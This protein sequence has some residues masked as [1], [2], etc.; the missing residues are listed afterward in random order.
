MKFFR[1]LLMSISA[2]PLIHALPSTRTTPPIH[3]IF[4]FPNLTALENVATRGNGNLLITATSSNSL[5]QL[6]PLSPTGYITVAT[7]PNV[8]SLLG[9]AEFQPDVFAVVAGNFTTVPP[10]TNPGTYSI[11]KVDLSRCYTR[12]CVG[13][14]T[15]ITDLPEGGLLN[16]MTLVVPGCSTA[17]VADSSVGVI[18]RVD[19]LTGAYKIAVNDPLTQGP[20]DGLP[21]PIGVNGVHTFGSTLYFTNLFLNGGFYA[22][23]PIHTSG[24]NIGFASGPASLVANIGT[25]DDF[26]L[27]KKGVAYVATNAQETVDRVKRDGSFAVI[28]GSFNDTILEGCTAA[29]FG[30]TAS[31]GAVL[32]VVTNGG[33]AGPVPG[34][35]REGGKV[36]AL[37]TTRL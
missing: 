31:D 27:D 9:I 4:Q 7:I 6:N 13:K 2:A 25:G 17:L 11:W 12:N 24:P 19:L 3:T 23:V 10:H 1:S 14:K 28:A 29:S 30:R 16:G 15:K 5:Y 21:L 18:W 8:T 22:Q 20:P 33:L 35:F 32:Y 36:V 34:T 37:D 26:A